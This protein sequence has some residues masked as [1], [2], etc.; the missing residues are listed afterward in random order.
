MVNDDYIIWLVVWNMF[1]L[2]IGNFIIPTDELIFFRGVGSTTN[3]M[4]LELEI[5]DKNIWMEAFLKQRS[6]SQKSSGFFLTWHF[7]I[8][9]IYVSI[10]VL[11]HETNYLMDHYRISMDF[12]GVRTGSNS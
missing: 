11:G 5:R 3:Q 1:F 12:Y 8:W 6:R 7:E 4:L 9:E 2:Y 10:V